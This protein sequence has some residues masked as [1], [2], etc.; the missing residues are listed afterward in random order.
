MKSVRALQSAKEIA[1]AA[2][3]RKLS[4]GAARI[5]YRAEYPPKVCDLSH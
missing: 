5:K 4:H 3:V 1:P 2:E